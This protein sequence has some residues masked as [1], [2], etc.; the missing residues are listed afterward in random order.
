MNR[1]YEHALVWVYSIF[2]LV[3]VYV[4][5]VMFKTWAGYGFYTTVP[6]VEAIDILGMHLP[7]NLLPVL[8]ACHLVLIPMTL[9]DIVGYRDDY[10]WAPVLEVWTGV[11]GLALTTIE[12][13]YAIPYGT[14]LVL[15]LCLFDFLTLI[16]SRVMHYTGIVPGTGKVLWLNVPI[17]IFWISHGLMEH[18]LLP[19]VLILTVPQL[20]LVYLG[21]DPSSI[22]LT[23]L[24][25]EDVAVFSWLYMMTGQTPIAIGVALALLPLLAGLFSS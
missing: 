15:C 2:L 16:S 4:A 19:V 5:V 13:R 20:Y 8:L 14:P 25:I 9:F 18:S 12:N 6:P 22:A 11:F 3:G 7:S 10:D 1:E 23:I 21:D 17:L 24:R